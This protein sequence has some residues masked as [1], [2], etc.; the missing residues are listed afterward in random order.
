MGV[1]H[2]PHQYNRCIYGLCR[3]TLGSVHT[4]T[5]SARS[6]RKYHI[7]YGI[8]SYDLDI[9]VRYIASGPNIYEI[10]LSLMPVILYGIPYSFDIGTCYFSSCLDR[11]R[12]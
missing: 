7:S 8:G 3:S 6:P 11:I 5:G 10:I 1:G 9:I 4:I 2:S 12:D